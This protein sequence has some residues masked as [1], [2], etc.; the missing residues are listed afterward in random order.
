MP[1]APLKPAALVKEL[2]S[3]H[4]FKLFHQDGD[5][6]ACF[7]EPS[8]TDDRWILNL[9]ASHVFEEDYHALPFETVLDAFWVHKQS[10]V[11][12]PL[13]DYLCHN[14]PGIPWANRVANAGIVYQHAD[15][16]RDAASV[17]S[18]S[19]QYDLALD[20]IKKAHDL[21]PNG[22]AILKILDDLQAKCSSVQ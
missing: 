10:L 16:F 18:N 22:P 19:G 15:L 2:L 6:V 13:S 12:D 3:I 11:K 8:A 5:Y 9:P 17:F 4:Q 1:P 20:F 21:R 14:G 7:G